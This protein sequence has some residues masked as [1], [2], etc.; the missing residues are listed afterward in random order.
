MHSFCTTK[1][2][3]VIAVTKD[4]NYYVAEIDPVVGGECRLTKHRQI[5]LEKKH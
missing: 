5:V 4:G 3:A 2:L 1:D